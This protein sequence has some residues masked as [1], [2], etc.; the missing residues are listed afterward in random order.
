MHVAATYGLAKLDVTDRLAL[1][2]PAAAQPGREFIVTA[3]VYNAVDGQKVTL[4]AS[5]LEFSP[6]TPA[7]QVVARGGK[8]TQVFWKVKGAAQG[9]FKIDATSE[10]GRAK[11]ISIMVQARSIFG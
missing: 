1:S 7:E 5:G 8:R 2:A 6:S 9:K 10:K 4:E 11:P 3:Y